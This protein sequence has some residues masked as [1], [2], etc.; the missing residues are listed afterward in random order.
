MAYRGSKRTQD[1]FDYVQQEQEPLSDS[2]RL[3]IILTMATTAV[4]VGLVAL[5]ALV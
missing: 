4:L 2:A 5:M 3:L 1:I